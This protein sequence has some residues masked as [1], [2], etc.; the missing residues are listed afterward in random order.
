MEVQ[1][2]APLPCILQA[3]LELCLFLH[4]SPTK[5]ARLMGAQLQAPLPCILQAALELCLSLLQ[6]P[7]KRLLRTGIRVLVL[8]RST[9]AVLLMARS[10]CMHLLVIRRQPPTGTR[11]RALLQSTTVEVHQEL[12][13]S[14]PLVIIKQP[15]RIG[16]LPQALARFTRMGQLMGLW[17]YS[18]HL[19]TRPRPHTGDRRAQV[20]LPSTVMAL[21]RQLFRSMPRAVIKLRPPTG[22]SP[23]VLAQF[24]RTDQLAALWRYSPH[25]ATKL[26]LR[27]GDRQLQAQAQS[28]HLDRPTGL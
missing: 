27:T 13:W 21:R 9:V 16:L 25:P 14:M 4:Q 17:R 6:S 3:A 28:T 23:Q 7:I 10:R 1:L 19:A 15:P 22:H 20:P 26:R 2:Q 8:L 18:P 5:P 12:F 24:T 11:V